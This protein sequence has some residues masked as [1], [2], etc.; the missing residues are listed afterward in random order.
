MCHNANLPYPYQMHCKMLKNCASSPVMSTEYPIAP[1]GVYTMRSRYTWVGGRPHP[2]SLGD[3]GMGV[4]MQICHT[5]THCIVL[6]NGASSP[7]STNFPIAPRGEYTM[8]TS[9]HLGWGKAT[10]TLAHRQWYGCH[11][12]NLPIPYPMHCKMLNNCASSPVRSMVIFPLPFNYCF[13]Y[14]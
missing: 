7:M 11:N 14:N 2:L 9:V 4:I 8:R 12:A 6:N 3:R 10:P 1:R 13:M 5:Y